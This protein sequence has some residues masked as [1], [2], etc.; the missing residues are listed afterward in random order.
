MGFSY[1]MKELLAWYIDL[2]IVSFYDESMQ[3]RLINSVTKSI[4][5][6]ADSCSSLQELENSVRSFE[7]CPLKKM[8]MNT[9]FSD[10]NSESKI[11]IIGEAPGATEDQKGIPFCGQSGKL[12]DNIL[13]SIGITRKNCYITNVV[14]WRPPGNRRPLPEELSVCRPFVEKHIA[15][16]KP[17]LIIL[18]G[19]TAAESLLDLK[20]PMNILRNQ[21]FEYS[22]KYLDKAVKTVV[23]LHPSY[24]LRQPMQK[25]T[26]WFD[27]LKIKNEF[28]YAISTPK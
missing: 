3:D 25:K 1:K 27:M 2:G 16:I 21:R 17:E 20:M 19:S 22:N 6:T 8:A 14:F 10:G 15:L 5:H 18:V 11:M 23:I 13:L 7:G 9:V 24:L 26:T 12:L 28:G 4:P